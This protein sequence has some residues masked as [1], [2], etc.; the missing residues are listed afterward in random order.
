MPIFEYRCSA[1]GDEF[2]LLVLPK[3]DSPRCPA[4]SSEDLEKTLSL[5]AVSSEHSRG[6][7]MQKAK[8]RAA[9]VRHDKEYHEHQAEHRHHH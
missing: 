1:C 2:E 3:S 8:K 7:A 9:E 5:S 4:C 6:H